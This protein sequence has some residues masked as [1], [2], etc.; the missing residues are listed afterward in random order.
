MQSQLAYLV[1][2]DAQSINMAVVATD[3]TSGKFAGID[4]LRY[5][6]QRADC[7]TIECK[8]KEPGGVPSLEDAQDWIRRLPVFL[9]YLK[10]VNREATVSLE[11]WTSGEI[12][13]DPLA[14]LTREKA[15]RTKNP[16][17]WR[18][19]QDVLALAASGKE[20]AIADALKQH[21]LHYPLA[22]VVPAAP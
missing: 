16:I 15:N 10:A 11:L 8:G 19:G 13:N 14:Y 12:A 3:S 1:R 6:N 9:S 18:V 5:T 2:R 17:A 4:I 7:V 20:K 22:K 21:F